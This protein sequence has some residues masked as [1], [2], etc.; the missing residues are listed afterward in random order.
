M[1]PVSSLS[2]IFDMEN[3]FHQFDTELSYLLLNGL[4]RFL[5]SPF[6]RK[7]DHFN[8]Q[9]FESNYEC[10]PHYFT[11]EIEATKE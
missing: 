10:I 6:H 8:Q 3:L 11:N 1:D 5:I 2:F 4:N 7:R 9:P